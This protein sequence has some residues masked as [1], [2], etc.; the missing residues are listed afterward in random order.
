MH[1]K[2]ERTTEFELRLVCPLLLTVANTEDSESAEAVLE[3]VEDL[4]EDVGVLVEEE[5]ELAPRLSWLLLLFA[6]DP[7]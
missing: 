5:E 4:K 7:E 1:T 2:M 3:E 6:I